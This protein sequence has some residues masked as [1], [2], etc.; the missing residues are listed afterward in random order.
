MRRPRP[1]NGHATCTRRELTKA[2]YGEIT[3]EIRPA[4]EF[5]FA[6][7]YHQ[8]YLVKVPNGYCPNHSTGVTL[9]GPVVQ[10]EQV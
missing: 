2:G 9:E 8:Q 6:E 1:P 4:G 10:M 5:Y 3:T 7:D